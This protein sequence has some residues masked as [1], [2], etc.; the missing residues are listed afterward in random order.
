MSLGLKRGTVQLMEYNSD[1]PKQFEVERQRLEKLLAGSNLVTI[2]HIGSTSI[3]GLSA[4]PLLDILVVVHNLAEAQKWTST[5]KKYG[6]YFKNEDRPERLF[7]AKGPES[8]RTVHLHIAKKN[9]NYV[10]EAL[11]FKNYMLDNPAKVQ[12]YSELKEQLAFKFP[13]DR[14][15]YT[16]GKEKFIRRILRENL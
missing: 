3:P 6:Y 15:E 2:E 12:E 9:S 7:F 16:K 11:G 5:L 10:K 8:K 13:E 4:K 1:W 14:Q